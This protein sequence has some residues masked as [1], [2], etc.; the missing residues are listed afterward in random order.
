MSTQTPM[1]QTKLT[2]SSQSSR[3]TLPA[4]YIAEM[5]EYVQNDTSE[6][7]HVSI[8]KV[9]PEIR[10]NISLVRDRQIYKLL[11]PLAHLGTCNEILTEIV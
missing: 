6:G 5:F 1:T 3:K 10:K 9:V 2:S 11:Y 7:R 4:S 8:N